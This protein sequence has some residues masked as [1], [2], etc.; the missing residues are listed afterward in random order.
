MRDFLTNAAEIVGLACITAG[1]FTL[2][3]LGAALVV[4]GLGL[5]VLGFLASG[6]NE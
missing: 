6:G 4:G 3:G 1:I 2:L 5:V